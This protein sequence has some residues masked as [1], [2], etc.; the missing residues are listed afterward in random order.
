MSYRFNIINWWLKSVYSC[1]VRI[2]AINLVIHKTNFV[3]IKL[4]DGEFIQNS[5]ST[6]KKWTSIELKVKVD[7][8][9]AVAIL[10]VLVV[11]IYFNA[12]KQYIRW[13]MRWILRI[14]KKYR[15]GIAIEAQR[16]ELTEKLFSNV[17]CLLYKLYAM[18]F[19]KKRKAAAVIRSEAHE[20]K[21]LLPRNQ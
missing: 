1:T 13:P 7:Q 15:N 20:L 10:T 5:I 11:F 16:A 21:T 18:L 14:I 8:Q 3:L 12:K 4:C 17:L 9:F 2:H 19:N 6:L